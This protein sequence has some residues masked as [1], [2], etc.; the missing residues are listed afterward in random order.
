LGKID[1]ESMFELKNIYLVLVE[2][3]LGMRELEKPRGRWEDNIRTAL[4]AE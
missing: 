2:K 4:K 3:Y 1:I